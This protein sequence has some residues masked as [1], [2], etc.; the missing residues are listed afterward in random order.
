[1]IRSTRGRDHSHFGYF[2]SC[3]EFRKQSFTSV[4]LNEQDLLRDAVQ[5]YVKEDE[6]K[7]RYTC[8]L[9]DPMISI[10]QTPYKHSENLRGL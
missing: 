6:G 9:K 3:I 10:T 1:M 7:D 2:Q 5:K 8:W 4:E